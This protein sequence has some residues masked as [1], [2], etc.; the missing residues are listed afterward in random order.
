MNCE[1]Y[2]STHVICFGN[3]WFG[4]DGFGIHVYR[5]LVELP[6]SDN[7]TLYDASILGMG[8]LN[9]FEG[10]D[11]AIVVDAIDYMGEAGK[12]HRLSIEDI[13]LI[14]GNDYTTH[15]MGLNHLLH[16]LPIAFSP[17]ELP[18][19]VI[20]AAEIERLSNL[21]DEL[22]QPMKKSLAETVKLIKRELLTHPL[23]SM[24]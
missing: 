13:K 15:T 9:C 8:A 23:E 2:N 11:K 3:L 18:K 22:S 6:L 7:V 5:Q 10:C 24:T 14:T 21:S 20:Y 17:Q 12:V 16:L 4:D 19:V 1:F